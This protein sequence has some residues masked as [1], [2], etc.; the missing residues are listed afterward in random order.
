VPVTLQRERA[1]H[2]D[3]ARPEN[4]KRAQAINP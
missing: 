2:A 1:A 3:D 4:R